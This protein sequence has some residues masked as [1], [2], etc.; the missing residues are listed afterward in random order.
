M[1]TDGNTPEQKAGISF[2]KRG[3][4]GD[5]SDTSLFKMMLR[6][7]STRHGWELVRVAQKQ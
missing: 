4:K 5:L 6:F 2:N 3:V 7:A 1:G